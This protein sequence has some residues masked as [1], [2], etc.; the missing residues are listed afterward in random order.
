MKQT[1]T[2]IT[3][4]LGERHSPEKILPTTRMICNWNG[5]YYRGV[6]TEDFI[7][8]CNYQE[9][10]DNGSVMMYRKSDLTLVCDNFH[11]SNDLVG[12]ILEKKYTYLSKSMQYNAR[13]MQKENEKYKEEE[14]ISEPF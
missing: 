1:T 4:V 5:R 9:G 7:Y 3:L 2:T 12:V 10:D 14:V 13:E 6:E 8:F 11:A